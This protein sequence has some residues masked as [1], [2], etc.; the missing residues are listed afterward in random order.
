MSRPVERT[1]KELCLICRGERWLPD[2]V[3]QGRS[4]PCPHCRGEGW[5]TV[6]AASLGADPGPD[7][8]EKEKPA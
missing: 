6:S 2:L 5:V 1:V 7:G 3:E 8:A 4:R